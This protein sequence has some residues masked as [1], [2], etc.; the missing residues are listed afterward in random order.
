MPR[1]AAGDGGGGAGDGGRDAAPLQ[2]AA[3]VRAQRR[4]DKGAAGRSGERADASDDISRSF[5]AQMV[6]ASPSFRGAGRLLQRLLRRLHPLAQARPSHRRIP[7]GRGRQFLHRISHRSGEGA[8]RQHAGAGHRHR[9][10]A[11]AAQFHVEGRR[12]RHQSRRGA[13]P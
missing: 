5:A 10:L 7:R 6:R 1:N 8:R 13:P 11:P 9:L 3:A 12:H 2:I 4:V